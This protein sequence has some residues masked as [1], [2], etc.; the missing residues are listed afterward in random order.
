MRSSKEAAGLS[1]LT[2][3]IDILPQSET[4]CTLILVGGSIVAQNPK[5]VYLPPREMLS[6]KVL[7]GKLIKASL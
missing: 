2:C 4:V 5:T 6:I 3:K 1:F 7:Q